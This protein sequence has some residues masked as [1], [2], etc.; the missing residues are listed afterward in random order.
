M[1]LKKESK[2]KREKRVVT[3]EEEKIMRWAVD[4]KKDQRREE[5]VE[6]NYR[7]I[8]KMVLQKFLKWRK[9]FGKVESERILMRK[10]WDHAIDLKKT[11][12]PK[13]ERIYSLSRNKREEVQNFI[14]D[15]LKK[16]YIRPLKFPQILPVF[17][18]SKKD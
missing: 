18:A 5:E 12:K 7:K 8:E 6:A 4:N 2:V 3:L 9:V 11:F 13:K 15:Q 1:K 16:R 14:E 10:I 17:F